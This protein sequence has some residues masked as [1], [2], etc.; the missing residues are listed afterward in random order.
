VIEVA[1]QAGDVF[2]WKNYP[3]YMDEFKSQRWLLYLGNQALEAMVYQITTTTQFHHY[4]SGGNRLGHNFFKIPAGIGGL[5]IDSILDL[6]AF[7]ERIPESLL[8]KCK[9]DIERTGAFN[10]DYVNK[11]VNHLKKDRHILPVFKKDIYG[12]L[13]AAKFLV[14]A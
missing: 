14:N 11:L 9:T 2:I 7:F 10:Q 3:L 4:E 1:L 6:T 5:A 8:N 13:K 12:Y